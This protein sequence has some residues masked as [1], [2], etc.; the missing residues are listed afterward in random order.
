MSYIN[1]PRCDRKAL[2]VASRCPHCGELFETWH[3]PKARP[4]RDLRPFGLLIVSAVVIGLVAKNWVATPRSPAPSP[5]PV[6]AS[7]DP[8]VPAKRRARPPVKSPAPPRS[9][10]QAALPPSDSG[11]R[12][13]AVPAEEAP[14]SETVQ[15]RYAGTWV[16]VR[17][18]RS[19]TA[20]VIRVLRPGEEIAVDVPRQGW[21]P[22]VDKQE[23]AGYVDGRYL[24]ATP[25]TDS[26]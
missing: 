19:N 14:D 25:P 22:V 26:L 15:A 7:A 11:T 9:P 24:E 17:A 18:G 16:N 23:T 3:Q 2:S 4:A 13:A 21:Y 5:G 20:P 8:R 1:C 10:P 12:L 6:A